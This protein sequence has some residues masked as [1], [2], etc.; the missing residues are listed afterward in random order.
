MTNAFASLTPVEIDTILIARYARRAD[1][2]REIGNLGQRLLGC[3]G[4]TV[5]VR[6]RDSRGFTSL[7]F[8]FV[9]PK[10]P[11]GFEV[12]SL[13]GVTLL[14]VDEVLQAYDNE[15]PYSLRD[16]GGTV[17]RYREVLSLIEDH[18]AEIQEIGREWE[19]RGC[20]SRYWLVTSSDGHIHSSRH[21]SSC[22]KGKQATG[23]ALVPY[24]SDKT[25]ADAV[26]DL[27]PALCTVCFPSAPVESR[28][29]ARI[30]AAVALAL[31]EAFQAARKAAAAK[32][33]KRSSELCSGSGSN[34]GGLRKPVCP[35]CGCTQRVKKDGTLHDHRAPRYY[36][37][38][39]QDYASDKFWTGQA[40]GPS[41][42]KAPFATREEA[43]A[44]PGATGVTWE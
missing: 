24:L 12:S 32:A 29:Q 9:H 5:T 3:Y 18:N 25:A 31:R 43:L 19:A 35:V 39:R 34:A 26:S 13:E 6:T 10:S 2:V 21:C 20:W 15:G 7:G 8:V 14:T 44:V 27:G 22:N 4:R 11:V 37:V 33:A 38:Q 36:A 28:E 17:S 42:K 1:L 30:P 16:E 23:F 41:T 40:W